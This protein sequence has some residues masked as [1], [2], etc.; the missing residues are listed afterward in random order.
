MIE[1]LILWQATRIRDDLDG[2]SSGQ[3]WIIPMLVIGSLLWPVGVFLA[4]RRYAGLNVV[5]SLIA[6]GSVASL[7]L[8]IQPLIYVVVAIVFFIA[9]VCF[10]DREDIQ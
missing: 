9:G 4:A 1:T 10:F 7:S 6:A 2:E 5:R 8:F 3:D